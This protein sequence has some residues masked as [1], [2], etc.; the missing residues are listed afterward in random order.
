MRRFVLF[1]MVAAATLVKST[2]LR[3]SITYTPL[4]HK[5]S[6]PQIPM[7]AK[8]NKLGCA[9]PFESY[10][11]TR[12][13]PLAQTSKQIDAVVHLKSQGLPCPGNVLSRTAVRL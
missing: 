5:R 6:A 11:L 12:S 1:P 13:G 3:I 4:L 10:P 7:T 9:H 2:N 8:Q